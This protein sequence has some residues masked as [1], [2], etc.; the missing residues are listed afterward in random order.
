MT[1]EAATIAMLGLGNFGTALAQHL[2]RAGHKVLGWSANEATVTSINNLGRNSG[3]LPEIEL[4]PHL[5]ATTALTDIGHCQTII[6]ALPSGAL[7]Q[8][9]PSLPV[10][11][12]THFV[13]LVKGLYGESLRTPLQAMRELLGSQHRYTVLSGPGFARDLAA[14]L[15]AGLVAASADEQAALEIATL[16]SRGRMKVYTSNDPLGVELGGILKNVL[17]IAVGIA[18]GLGFGDSARAGL[19]TRGLAEMVRF[20]CAFGAKT[21]TLFGLSGV[22]DLV[23]T[24]TCDTSR[25]RTVGLRLGA[26]ESLSSIVSSMTSVAEGVRATPLVAELAAANGIEVPITEQVCKVITGE[27]EPLP[28]M[29]ALITRPVR[30]EFS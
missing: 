15:P 24:A 23:L 30:P 5:K 18:D 3:Y 8:V 21:E 27:L 2:A 9:L 26:G 1:D 22:G 7:S 25:N 29:K 6:V 4:S 28:A 16:F 20:A 11:Q 17:A 13:S 10:Q 14:G 19:I 12:A